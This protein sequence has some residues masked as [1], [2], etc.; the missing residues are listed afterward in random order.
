MKNIVKYIDVP[1]KKEDILTLTKKDFTLTLYPEHMDEINHMRNLLVPNQS[2]ILYFYFEQRPNIEK[3]DTFNLRII[4]DNDSII[5][6]DVKAEDICPP[7]LQP[8]TEEKFALHG[9]ILKKYLIEPLVSQIKDN[10]FVGE[11]Q[12]TAWTLYFRKLEKKKD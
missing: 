7:L 4:I 2:D 9:D 3:N 8:P 5:R 12:K 11:A 1:S 6:Y 10:Y